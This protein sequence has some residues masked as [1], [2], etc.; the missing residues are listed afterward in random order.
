M[1]WWSASTYSDPSQVFHLIQAPSSNGEYVQKDNGLLGVDILPGGR[2]LDHNVTVLP[3]TTTFG[4]CYSV[5]AHTPVV[6]AQALTLQLNM[7]GREHIS[8]FTHNPGDQI[9]LYHNYW[10]SFVAY[11]QIAS[12]TQFDMPMVKKIYNLRTSDA[13][14]C[15]QDPEYDYSKCLM[16]WAR[17]TYLNSTCPTGS[18]AFRS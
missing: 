5:I 8:T 14:P 7:T 6:A 18:F 9:G 17:K 15:N 3:V 2:D 13:R 1:S 11:H 12:R 4:L 10:P 16:T